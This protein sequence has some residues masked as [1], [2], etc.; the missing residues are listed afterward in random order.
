MSPSVRALTG[1]LAGALL[2]LSPLALLLPAGWR[3]AAAALLLAAGWLLAR[4]SRRERAVV[5][6]GFGLFLAVALLATA[7]SIRAGR[8]DPERELAEVRAAVL[9]EWNRLDGEAARVATALGPAPAGGREE[10][11]TA[12]RALTELAAA[13]GSP[14]RPDRSR[15]HT[16]AGRR[17]TPALRAGSCRLRASCGRAGCPRH[18]ALRSRPLRRAAGDWCASSRSTSGV[19]VEPLGGHRL[20]RRLFFPDGE[21]S[22]W[23]A[24][25]ARLAGDAG[26]GSLG[27]ASPAP[28]GARPPAGRAGTAVLAAALSPFAVARESASSC[29]GTPAARF[30]RFL[31]GPVLY[32]A[33]GGAG[34]AG[35]PSPGWWSP[36]SPPP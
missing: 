15:R 21:G 24:G 9:R 29:C 36:R 17:L 23:P 7:L 31:A 3:T 12:F 14:S 32:A 18:R 1:L 35:L 33:L 20:V 11:A 6:A 26:V 19:P 16:V 25:R 27:T 8:E 22:R 2:V 5:Y 13:S 28:T 30:S 34:G 4:H 10:I